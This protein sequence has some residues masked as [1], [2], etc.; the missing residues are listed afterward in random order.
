MDPVA[1]AV[2]HE[3]FRDSDSGAEAPA[4]RLSA[5][6]AVKNARAPHPL[7][8]R[9]VNVT[10]DV[11]LADQLEV[12]DSF[13]KRFVGLLGRSR[14]PM[15]G[16]LLITRCSSVHTL[17]MAFPLDVLH[18]DD[19]GRVR[20]IIPSMQPWRVGPWVRGSTKVLELPGGASNGTQ[21]GDTIELD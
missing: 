18:L 21:L 17:A 2:L 20:A 8:R 10:R 19:A 9:A 6:S 13:W 14:L 7:T 11:V 1:T 5:R 16:G 4:L 15:G 3:R 12:A